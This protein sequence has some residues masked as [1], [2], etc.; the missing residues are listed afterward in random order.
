MRRGQI[1]YQSLSTAEY[2]HYNTVNTHECCSGAMV[3]T[4]HALERVKQFVF[5]N[6]VLKGSRESLYYPL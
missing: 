6:I 2:L 4:I 5:F 1:P 3:R